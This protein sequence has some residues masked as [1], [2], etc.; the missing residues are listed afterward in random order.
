M[1]TGLTTLESKS[2]DAPDETRPFSHGKLDVVNIGGTVVGRSTFEPGWKWSE[3]VKPIAGTDNCQA[4]HLGYMISGRMQ[5]VMNDGTETE[6][7]PGDA[8]VIPPGHDAWIVGDETCV[9]LDFMGAG[10]YAK[11]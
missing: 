4:T 2:L 6:L 9:F 10:Q 1:T 5:V 3:Y 7:G 8:A 11:R